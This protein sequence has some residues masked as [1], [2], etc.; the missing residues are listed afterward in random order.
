MRVYIDTV[1]LTT[2]FIFQ[3]ADLTEDVDIQTRAPTDKDKVSYCALQKY[4]IH[5][6]TLLLLLLLQYFIL[7]L[8]LYNFNV[9]FSIL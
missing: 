2:C 3:L 4:Y 6:I 7:Y 8:L 1:I 5:Y 9:L